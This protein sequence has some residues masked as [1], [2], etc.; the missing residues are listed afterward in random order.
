MDKTINYMV[1]PGP[2]KV[3]GTMIMHGANYYSGGPVVI[4]KLDLGE[5]DEVFTDAI[6]GFYEKLR[7]TLPSLYEHHCSPGR[8]GGF[9]E[10][11]QGGTLLGHVTEHVAIELQTLAGMDVAYGKTRSTD[12]QGVYH[13]VFRLVDEVAGL[14]AGKAGVNLV[15][16]LLTDTSF[17][18][19]EVLENLIQIREKRLLGPSTQAVTA[20]ADKRKIPFL[21]LDQYNL[22]Q[23][24]TGKY[25][26]RI[27]ATITSDTSFVAV[28]TVADK[29]L[30]TLMLRDAGIPTPETV[31]VANP[32]D[33]AD[34]QNQVRKLVTIKPRKGHL[35][36]GVTV[37]PEP[38]QVPAAFEWAKSYD[39]RVLAQTCITGNA[40]RILVIDY[41]FVAAVKLAPPSVTGDGIR[42]ISELI[43]GL[44]SDSNRGVGDMARMT[45]VEMDEITQRILLDAGHSPESILPEKKTLTLKQSGSLRLGG[46]AV[47]A[48]EEVH[49]MNRF[50]AER[51][52]MTVGLNVAG[53][54]ILA[55]TLSTSILENGG[56][57]IEI[58]SAPDFRMHLRPA[59]GRG[60]NVAGNFLDMLFPKGS[61]TH[62]PLFSVTGTHGRGDAVRRLARCLKL[63]GHAAV[64][65]ASAEGLHLSERCLAEGDMTAPEQ[66]SLI[67]KDPAIDCAVLETP[68][69]GIL[70]R[71]LGYELADFGMVLNV[72]EKPLEIDYAKEIEDVAYAKSVV[73]EQVYKEGYTILNADN[74]LV[75]EMAERAGGQ[76]I[77]FSQNDQNERLLAHVENGGIGVARD[78]RDVVIMDGRKKIRVE[79]PDEMMASLEGTEIHTCEVMLVCIAALYAFGA[80]IDVIRE[81]L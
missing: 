30:T 23:L 68:C 80:P 4:I 10:R 7:K 20:E 14:Y 1:N 57:V 38:E 46:S 56:A 16:A 76:V 24:G 28:E 62:V 40:Y 64:G 60:R 77:F 37:N 17:D 42:T 74:D 72:H 18:A 54:D 67:L 27:R 22:V 6:P 51:A 69:E 58:N 78:R 50:L 36:K 29:Y 35:G 65:I 79:L 52:S 53:V 44:N 34:F 31:R 21:R 3:L 73:A 33:V 66:V 25:Q 2:L 13:V 12:V 43:D 32:Q 70:R 8:K 81:G 5:Y 15:N 39:D 71:G 9:F 26:K 55:P 49:E 75:A 11:V 45:R 63:S 47:D 41:Q 59:V 48:T 19:N 61:K